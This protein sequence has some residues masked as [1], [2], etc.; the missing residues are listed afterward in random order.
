MSIYFTR[1]VPAKVCVCVI[2]SGL[3]VI[4]YETFAKSP[5][6]QPYNST[7][8]PCL[9]HLFRLTYQIRRDMQ[10]HTDMI[11][12]M[13]HAGVLTA[14]CE[15][16][17]FCFLVSGFSLP[18]YSSASSACLLSILLWTIFLSPIS[19][20]KHKHTPVI[21]SSFFLFLLLPVSL[22]LSFCPFPTIR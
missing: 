1:N 12:I 17:K 19:K 16:M 4:V 15:G 5:L 22:F 11:K 9:L 8:F 20:Q 10:Q 2:L 13:Q 6:I 14:S 18:V 3:K 21:F 7:S